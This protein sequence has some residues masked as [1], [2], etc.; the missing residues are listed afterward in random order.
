M[1]LVSYYCYV[2]LTYLSLLRASLWNTM[3]GTSLLAMPWAVAQSGLLM[4]VIVS[5][6]LGT[7]ATSTAVLVVVLH[8]RMSKYCYALCY[9]HISTW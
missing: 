7:I 3:M 5:L 4:A 1:C 2:P 6:V 9:F 8:K